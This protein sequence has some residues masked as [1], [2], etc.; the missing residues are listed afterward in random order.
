MPESIREAVI[1]FR[2]ETLPAYDP[3]HGTPDPVLRRRLDF[4][5]PQGEARW[6]Q[7]DYGHP[8]RCNPWEP[9][10]IDAPLQPRTAQLRAVAEA[11]AALLD[12]PR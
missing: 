5:L 9:R 10:G 6:E 11:L 7:S 8:G 2:E 1:R 12:N 4:Q 3:S